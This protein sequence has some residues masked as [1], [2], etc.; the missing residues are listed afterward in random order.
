MGASRVDR[1]S[2]TAPS[3]LRYGEALRAMLDALTRRLEVETR[4]PGLNH[5]VVSAFSEAWNNVVWHAYGGRR[6]ELV[7]IA[8]E[9]AGDHLAVSLADRGAAFDIEAVKPPDLD[10]QPEGGLGLYIIRSTMSRVE[11]ERV[12]G[13]N[14]I[15]MTKEFAEPLTL[16]DT[17]QEEV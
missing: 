12:D 5:H 15:R 4:T 6:T 7:E 2:V 1:I 13:R 17:L 14:V 9:V 16:P 10:A 3:D 11:H 8:I